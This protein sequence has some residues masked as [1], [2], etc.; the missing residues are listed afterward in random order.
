MAAQRP[1]DYDLNYKF[2]SLVNS[3]SSSSSSTASMTETNSSNNA[4]NVEE[5]I[6]QNTDI[7]NKST[8]MNDLDSQSFT[9]FAITLSIIIGFASMYSYKKSKQKLRKTIELL[10]PLIDKRG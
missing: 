10:D 1:S 2:T 6:M 4:S 3:S 8:N 9:F 5:N 7:S